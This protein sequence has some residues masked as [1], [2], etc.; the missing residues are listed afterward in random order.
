M[1]PSFFIS[2]LQV[3]GQT[4]TGILHGSSL[5][6]VVHFTSNKLA[7]KQDGAA[8]AAEGLRDLGGEEF[9]DGDGGEGLRHAGEDEL[10]EQQRDGERGLERVV[11]QGGGAALLLHH[12]RR[13]HA[14]DG[15]HDAGADF[16]ARRHSH[17]PVQDFPEGDDVEALVHQNP[18][19]QGDH[20]GALLVHHHKAPQTRNPNWENPKQALQ[21]LHLINA[22]KPPR[23]PGNP[24]LI[25]FTLIHNHRRLIEKHKPLRLG[26]LGLLRGRVVERPLPQLNM[27]LA[28]RRHYD[29]SQ[30]KSGDSEPDGPAHFRLDINHAREDY[31]ERN[32]EGEIPPIDEALELRPALGR[33]GVE[34][35]RPEGD[36]AGPNPA[37]AQEEIKKGAAPDPEPTTESRYNRGGAFP[38]GDSGPVP[39]PGTAS[40]TR[41]EGLDPES[42]AA[43]GRCGVALAS[44]TCIAKA[45]SSSKGVSATN[46]TPSGVDDPLAVVS[47]GDCGS[48]TEVPSATFRFRVLRSSRSESSEYRWGEGA[49][50]IEKNCC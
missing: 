22:T 8:E 33:V 24:L 5:S 7:S 47:A 28:Y 6:S 32:G 50:S 13:H 34:L 39:E 49:F 10:R 23:V 40:D 21:L 27:P 2:V 37:G 18:E 19:G 36:V 41:P 14:E 1:R 46:S 4:P 25:Q 16:L 12:A 9:H 3:S 11:F 31:Q 42:D 15:G 45:G 35:V 26:Q 30:A 44:S 43:S 48:A 17:V 20:G 29:F 38:I